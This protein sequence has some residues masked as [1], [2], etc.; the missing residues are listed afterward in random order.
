MP[1]SDISRLARSLVAATVLVL[2][3]AG[4]A[5][6]GGT[7]DPM[8]G[9]P[10][11]GDCY[12]LTVKQAYAHAAAA[13]TVSC[14]DKHTMLVVAVGELPG[15]LDWATLDL[16]APLPRGVVRT[17]NDTCDAAADKLIGHSPVLR[18]LSIYQQFWFS[19]TTAQ[20]ADG[21][22]WFS[23]EVSARVTAGLRP[24]AAAPDKLT[25]PVPDEVAR[26][27]TT[28][29]KSYPTVACSS[30]HD[31]RATYAFVVQKKPTDKAELSAAK[32]TCGRH[33]S[34]RSWLWTVP[35]LDKRSFVI[36][37]LAQTHH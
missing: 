14:S 33:V 31:W 30:R 27:A 24:L 1:V 28:T 19:P 18:A 20:I 23:C 12:N 21:A 15:S 9:A 29:K 25:K 36:T 35:I 5:Q 34:S 11:V 13:E 6:A 26:C 37:C 32:H 8:A 16:D 3:T 22:R 2:T 17:I 10:A 4:L 7:T